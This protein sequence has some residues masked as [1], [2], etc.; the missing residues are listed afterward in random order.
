MGMCVV[1]S[2]RL[3]LNRLGIVLLISLI[4]FSIPQQKFPI[5]PIRTV[6]CSE[7]LPAIYPKLNYSTFLGGEDGGEN[8][9]GI[10]VTADGSYYITGQTK[11]SDF[12][13]QNAYDNTSNGGNDAVV[14]KFACNNSL[15]WSTYLGGGGQVDIAQSIAVAA[16]GSCYVTGETTSSDFPTKNAF[17]NT[18][19]GGLTDA[20]VTK[21]AA[22]GSL[23]WSTYL[24]GGGD[25]DIGQSIAVASDG[26]CYVTG[27][28]TSSDFPIQNG[29]D[30]T[31]NGGNFDIFLAK[32]AAN[33]SLLWSTF[34]GGNGTEGGQG[35]AV[36]SDGSCYVTGLTRSSDF[37]TQNA[38]DSTYNGGFS[39]VFVTKFS[40]EGNL[41]W[42]TLLGGIDWDEGLGI[43]TVSDVSCYV[44]GYTGS[45]DFP[46]QFPYNDTFG[47]G[48]D[49]F[50]AMFATNGS[51]LWST[52]L[53][54]NSVDR[55]YDVAVISDGSCYITGYTGSENFP[56]QHAYDDSKASGYDT[57]VTKFSF[58]GSLFW[59]T[60]IGG[61]KTD[62]AY[63][64]AATNSG[65]CYV[66]GDTHR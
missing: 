29:Y 49:A 51:L 12:P 15:L 35:L 5:D 22:N 26:S 2:F 56:S 40:T 48:G 6:I 14:T 55:A 30:I 23:L 59:S 42:S 65:F 8:G 4:V 13:T 46:T 44:T 7:T 41:L 9:R 66:V 10:A 1:K 36:A 50:L 37:P 60:Y 24:G 28:T 19:N 63:S 17:D 34:L 20:F 16:D 53:G 45:P 54:G 57:F 64:I 61:N 3:V 58:N 21:F 43:A 62:K 11:S 33:G 27:E 32:F 39:D 38:Y 47:G 31:Y 18:F 25:W 52:F